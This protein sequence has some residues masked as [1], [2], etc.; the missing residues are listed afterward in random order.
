MSLKGGDNM[1]WIEIILITLL[2]FLI[3]NLKLTTIYIKK[4]IE[5]LFNQDVLLID[6]IITS[7]DKIKGLTHE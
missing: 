6:H 4:D 3:I 1:K 7:S 5:Q 2:L